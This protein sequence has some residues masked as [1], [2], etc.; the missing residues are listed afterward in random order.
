MG[1]K[2]GLALGIAILTEPDLLILDEPQ[3]GLDPQG[4]VELRHLLRDYAAAGRTVLVS[5]HQLGEITQ[6]ADDISALADARRRYQGTLAYFA[7]ARPLEQAFLALT[8]PDAARS[9]AACYDR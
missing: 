8:L 5:S 2:A 1:T 4:I 9:D 6:L 7:P 3:N